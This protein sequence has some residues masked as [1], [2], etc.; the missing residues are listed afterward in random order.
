MQNKKKVC[1]KEEFKYRT[2]LDKF[3]IKK[4][5]LYVFGLWLE[6]FKDQK[7]IHICVNKKELDEIHQRISFLSK[8]VCFSCDLKN[9]LFA[10]DLSLFINNICTTLTMKKTK[11]YGK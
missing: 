10:T 2:K 1:L 11:C 6:I 7:G 5:E 3:N 9:V 8:K 4:E